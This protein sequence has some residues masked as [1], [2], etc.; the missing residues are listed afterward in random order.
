MNFI[1]RSNSIDSYKYIINI[2]NKNNLKLYIK[3]YSILGF[4]TYK[5]YIP[6]LSNIDMLDDLKLKLYSNIKELKNDY[7]NF[8]ELKG[9]NNKIFENIFEELSNSLKYSNLIVPYN[10]FDVNHYVDNDYIKLNYFYLLVIE[11]IIN[12]KYEKAKK[13]I[14]KRINSE[15]VSNYEKKYLEYLSCKLDNK[16]D[17]FKKFPQN[18]AT[19]VDLLLKDVEIY[20]KKINVLNCPN[21]KTCK[22]KKSCKYKKWLNINNIL[23]NTQFNSDI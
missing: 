23:K 5:V 14:E 1:N 9:K 10:L 6:N 13:L 22:S 21:C 11:L 19:D 7:Y 8:E 16:N 17:A 4:D 2:I 12:K 18:I 3:D 20:L 15:M